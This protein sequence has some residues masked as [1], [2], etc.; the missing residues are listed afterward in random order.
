MSGGA[1]ADHVVRVLAGTVFDRAPRLKIVPRAAVPAS[2]W[3]AFVARWPDA[4][5]WH[6]S[7]WLDYTLRCRP[8][9]RDASAAVVGGRGDVV[10][11]VPALVDA[12]GVVDFA[13]RPH[14][15]YEY[16]LVDPSA[17]RRYLVDSGVKRA[18]T[19]GRPDQSY[20]GRGY[21]TR[22]L[23]L[24]VDGD[25]V[26]DATLWAGVRSSY[27][28]PIRRAEEQYSIQIVA[29][30]ASG[31]AID[32]CRAIHAEAAGRMTRPPETWTMMGDWVDKGLAVVALGVALD[33]HGADG[34]GYAY[35]FYWK[36]WG[37]YGSGASLRRDGLGAA[38]QWALIRW[39]RDVGVRRY[40]LGYV[41]EHPTQK[42]IAI[43]FFKQGFGGCDWPV[44]VFREQF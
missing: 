10:G 38:L 27:H 9:L 24:A 43:Q 8:E 35:A 36:Q 40:E 12:D 4:W 22:V 20:T 15:A 32:E 30:C 34:V 1:F 2:L 37:Y 31:R 16:D 42:D 7:D 44:E 14:P 41:P 25:P 17:V 33:G 11:V 39:L 29:D 3:D 13:G 26:S 19:S 5:W 23:E 6:R 28:S 21:R 18:I